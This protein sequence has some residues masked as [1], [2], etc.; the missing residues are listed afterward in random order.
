ML[1]RNLKINYRV[2]ITNWFEQKQKANPRFSLGALAR[3]LGYSSTSS[4]SN[5]LSGKRSL[6]SK[7]AKLLVE[8]MELPPGQ[9]R[10]FL[11]AV[12]A[13]K[14]SRK[15]FDTEVERQKPETFDNHS[16]LPSLTLA[17]FIACTKV[18]TGLTADELQKVSERISRE[19]KTDG[20]RIYEELIK[21]GILVAEENSIKLAQGKPNPYCSMSSTSEDKHMLKSA[22]ELQALAVNKFLEDPQQANIH[23]AVVKVRPE[24][25]EAMRDDLIDAISG[26]YERYCFGEGRT[27]LT[28]FQTN[29]VKIE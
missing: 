17:H 8:I 20:K 2:L 4:L 6:S 19:F 7:H 24:E 5:V 14:M 26:V 1:K 25:V 10:S 29:F 11:E 28:G 3:K 27:S 23:L 9:A 18:G 12:A 16:M 13:E 15:G 22:Q 21:H